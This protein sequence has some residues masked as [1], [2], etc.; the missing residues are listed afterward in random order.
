MYWLNAFAV[1]LAALFVLAINNELLFNGDDEFN[2]ADKYELIGLE[3]A[4]NEA[5]ACIELNHGDMRKFL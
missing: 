5:N 4:F 2:V 1:K 3:L